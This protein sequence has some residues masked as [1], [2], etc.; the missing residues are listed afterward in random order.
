MTAQH[1]ISPKTPWMP[2]DDWPC[3]NHS[4]PALLQ[5][6]FSISY[7]LDRCQ[8]GTLIMAVSAEGSESGSFT[9]GEAAAKAHVGTLGIW[10]RWSAVTGGVWCWSLLSSQSPIYFKGKY[11]LWRVILARLIRCREELGQC[12]HK[13]K[14]QNIGQRG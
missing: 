14:P 13:S 12:V 5:A 3:D 10:H 11:T 7:L 6:T 2:L 1:L 8:N 4:E 9:G